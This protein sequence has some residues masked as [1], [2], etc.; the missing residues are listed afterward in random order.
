[1][2]N[3]L[4]TKV[5]SGVTRTFGKAYRSA[6][7][8]SPLLLTVGGVLGLGATAYLAYKSAGKVEKITEAIEDRRAQEAEIDGLMQI[9]VRDLTEEQETKIKEF[10]PVKRTEVVRDLAGAL[11]LPVVTGTLSVCSIALGYYILNNRLLNVAASLATATAENVFYRQK[12]EKKYGKE[13]A[14][15]FYTP[16]TQ[17]SE[18]VMN[19]NGK[20]EEV[21]KNDKHTKKIL[22]GVWFDQSENYVSD[23]H[24]YNLAQIKSAEEHCSLKLFR[25]GVLR[26]NE[27]R[28]ALGVQ[29][30]K[31]GEAVGWTTSDTSFFLSETIHR[32]STKMVDPETGE[33]VIK[34]LPQIYI[35]WPTPHYIYDD[36]DYSD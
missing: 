13:Q 32:E 15:E 28:D 5:V 36:V 24:Q 6:A 18:I 1:M 9:P 17:R 2:K 25:A 22:N 3:I 4:D 31:D 16:D 26:L 30:S 27:V 35:S 11:A 8:H 19:E 33:I 10:T 34:D 7:K 20:E 21:I 12:F 14:Q 23:D 29:R